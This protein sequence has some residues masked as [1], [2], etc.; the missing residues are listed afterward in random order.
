MVDLPERPVTFPP[1]EPSLA[2]VPLQALTGRKEAGGGSL[3]RP[4]D[5]QTSSQSPWT[6][7]QMPCLAAGTLD[8]GRV[9]SSHRRHEPPTP[10]CLSLRG[11]V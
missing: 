1:C 10:T 3:G 2:A 9:S 7:T 11:L 4:A 6:C 5:P 8:P